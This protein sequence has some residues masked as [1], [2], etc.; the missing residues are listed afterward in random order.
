M[1]DKKACIKELKSWIKNS[2]SYKRFAEKQ[3]SD[4]KEV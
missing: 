1:D 4:Y 2:K 3:T